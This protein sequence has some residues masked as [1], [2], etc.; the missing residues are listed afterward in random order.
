MNRRTLWM[1]LMF[2]SIASVA[3]LNGC[4]G[5]SGTPGAG[6]IKVVISTA[7][8][9][10]METKGTATIVATVSNDK[11][12]GGVTWSCTPVNACGSFVPP[13]SASG[14][15]VTYTAPP[16]VPAGNTV[17]ITATSVTNDKISSTPVSVTIL[18]PSPETFIFDLNGLEELNQKAGVPNFY[19]LAGAVTIDFTTGAVTGGEQDYNDGSGVAGFTSPQ[20]Q[21]DS[22]TG[23]TLSINSNGQGTLTLITN[24]SNLGVKGT[25]TLGV[26]FVNNKHALVMQFDGSA[27]SSGSMDLQTLTAPSGNFSFAITGVDKKFNPKVA[28]GVFTISGLNLQNGIADTDNTEAGSPSLGNPFSGTISAPDAFGRGSVTSAS[29]GAALNYYVVGA[30][31]LRLI[32]V[33]TTD[34]AVG[35]AYGQGAG[36]FSNAS[37]GSSVF[38]IESNCYGFNSSGGILWA[39][40]GQLT[41]SNTGASPADFSAIADENE[42]G[43]L[44]SVP[45]AA[46]SVAGT[47]T[48]AGNGYGSMTVTPTALQSVS[49]LGVYMVDTKI[50]INDPN[51]TATD[52]GGALLVDLDSTL[53]GVGFLVPQ[54]STS[55]AKFTGDYAFGAQDFTSITP[56]GNGFEFDFV[57]QGATPFSSAPGLISDPFGIFGKT[58]TISNATFSMTPSADAGNPGRYTPSPLTITPQPPNPTP[59]PAISYNPF[60]LATAIYQAD[61]G[62]L[63]WVDD[64]LSTDN[65]TVS[66]FGGTIQQQTLPITTPT[67]P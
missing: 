2:A 40:A 28:G 9:A 1:V 20:P 46:A 54:T 59:P 35:S 4:E 63:V 41:T 44:A 38:A 19:A 29:F 24:N 27:T 39:A 62:L 21:G 42:N 43:S 48:I 55:S 52:L 65:V 50:N 5:C 3:G 58:A 45:P 14:A 23:G 56:T 36:P 11:K 17:T 53:D 60:E 16:A 57:G 15:N 12:N 10:K 67:I 49:F 13:Q 18:A 32:I 26:Q 22:I 7:P 33:D 66:I 47:Y 31:V 8:P 34:S 64:N 61:G 30:E 25:E 6:E 51:N 37:L